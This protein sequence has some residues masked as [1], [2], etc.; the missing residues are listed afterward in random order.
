MKNKNWFT[1]EYA[2]HGQNKSSG[3][4][5]QLTTKKFSI[6]LVFSWK[7][8]S[9]THVAIHTNQFTEFILP[10]L[11]AIAAPIISTLA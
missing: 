4:I 9:F 5:G 3:L 1:W 2:L 6:L 8:K 10:L 11:L 7:L